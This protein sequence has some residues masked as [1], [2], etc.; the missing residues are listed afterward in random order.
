MSDITLIQDINNT[1]C[2]SNVLTTVEHQPVCIKKADGCSYT[3]FRTVRVIDN[4]ESEVFI[5]ETGDITSEI[6]E[7]KA[8][9][10]ENAKSYIDTCFLPEQYAIQWSWAGNGTVTSYNP[11]D[12]VVTNYGVTS[13]GGVT[14]GGFAL[15]FKNDTVEPTL[16]FQRSGKLYKASPLD[17]IGTFTLVGNTTG[18]ASSYPCFDFDP[19][20][21]LLLG[22]GI[23]VW[24]VN[25]DT[26]VANYLGKI[27][28]KRDGAT[29]S[30]SPGDWFF[31]PNGQW[32]MMARDNR[33][34][35]FL[36][37]NGVPFCTGTVLWKI[38]VAT[39]EATRVSQSCSPVSGTGASW[40]S[41]G[42]S[43]LSVGSG[44]VYEYDSY[45][46]VWQINYNANTAINDLASQWIIPSPIRVFGWVDSD[47]QDG[48]DCSLKLFN[49]EQNEDNTLS[50]K[51]FVPTLKGS[52]GV[53]TPASNPFVSDP[54]SPSSGSSEKTYS[55][56]VWHEG[57]SSAGYTR[58]RV[59][60]DS[61]GN[62]LIEYI[63]GTLSDP[64]SEA[65]NNFFRVPCGEQSSTV[66]TTTWCNNGSTIFRKEF[67]TGF[68]RWFDENG[69]ISTTPSDATPGACESGDPLLPITEQVVC[70][71]GNSYVRQ[72]REIYIEDIDGLP[73]LVSTQYIY[74]NEDGVLWNS[75]VVNTGNVNP[76]G[77][78]TGYYLGDCQNPY[79]E[80]INEKLCEFDDEKLLLID[81]G[82]GFAEYSFQTETYTNITSLS[83]P[84][85]GGSA[86]PDE[87]LLYSF[88]APNLM[89]VIDVNTKAILNQIT[90]TSTDGSPLTF[91]AAS[92]DVTDGFL[93]STD[94]TRIYRTNVLTGVVTIY[95]TLSGLLGAGTSMAIDFDGRMIIMGSAGRVFEINRITGVATLIYTSIGGTGN[96]STF[97]ADN[98]L[99]LSGGN[100]TYKIQNLGSGSEIETNIIDDWSPGANSVA[101]YRTKAKTPSC[102]HRRYGILKN[103]NREF[104][105]D[106]FLGTDNVR[107]ISG[108]VGC[109]ECGSGSSSTSSTVSVSNFPTVQNVIVDNFPSNQDVTVSNFPSVQVLEKNEICNGVKT[110]W[111]V[112]TVNNT[113]TVVTTYEDESG[114][115]PEPTNWT[116]G[117][118]EEEVAPVS[119]PA[120]YNT[121][122]GTSATANVGSVTV[123]PLNFIQKVET[124]P[125]QL[126]W[127]HLNSDIDGAVLTI[128]IGVQS[129]TIAIGDSNGTDII[130]TMNNG[131]KSVPAF[132]GTIDGNAETNN[133]TLAH[134]IVVNSNGNRVYILY[135]VLV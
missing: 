124:L 25:T 87:F 66:E 62:E 28:D 57:C 108:S 47:C 9:I 83:V 30:A 94:N 91:S 96:G 82:G 33:G 100:N 42:K 78:P 123:P 106:Y 41:A 6:V 113:G 58:W 59:Y 98:N 111:R 75:G 128:P 107:I 119:V 79:V 43:L 17:P 46:D 88:V 61:A 103:G 38:D 90:L 120:T 114:I 116:V 60:Y 34:A 67:N 92:F 115:V 112:L 32:Y 27:I 77:E 24:E 130:V 74:F 52:L 68:I 99:Y 4:V 131:T 39:L 16:Y 118:C 51:V 70:F 80:I 48:L 15:A 54:F 133:G 36:D 85:A 45:T 64:V 105:N 65:P 23:N 29:I 73:E 26:A 18:A 132:V 129:W 71:E 97:D 101:Y 86:N 110:L 11:I 76:P 81:S 102:F 22:D 109:C 12:G 21:R 122:N 56:Q 126:R 104:I 8:G 93:Y 19:S 40:L 117:K 125:V 53:C 84:S 14:V 63:Y 10:C 3:A 49:L 134:P 127:N 135:S 50:C 20:G 31:D 121:G 37:N 35:S 95:L 1:S 69:T 89:Y 2:N 44:A 7:W 5:D 55:D 72:V 13:F